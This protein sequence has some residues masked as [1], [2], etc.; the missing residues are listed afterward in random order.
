LEPAKPDRV[1]TLEFAGVLVYFK[2]MKTLVFILVLAISSQPF[3][4]GFCDLSPETIQGTGHHMD[5]PDQ[6][7]HDC[8]D[9]KPMDSK[10]QCDN[11]MNCSRC[12]LPISALP[13]MLTP[14]S[15]WEQCWFMGLSSGLV[16]PSHSSP[17]FRPPIS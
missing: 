4:A 10:D 1:K 15:T 13:V 17:P 6:G 16:L 5:D 2:V 7:S 3:Q 14:A 8:C 11:G 9:P 12:F